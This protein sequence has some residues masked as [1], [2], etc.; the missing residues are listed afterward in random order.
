MERAK[1]NGVR[2]TDIGPARAALLEKCL[3]ALHLPPTN[4]F[5]LF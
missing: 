2:M 4:S 3:G 5:L 1:Q